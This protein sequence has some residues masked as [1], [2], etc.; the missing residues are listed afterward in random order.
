MKCATFIS[1]DC[2][3]LDF[4]GRHQLLVYIII[5]LNP[6]QK[7]GLRNSHLNFHRLTFYIL[8][9]YRDKI[10]AWLEKTMIHISKDINHLQ[11]QLTY[12]ETRVLVTNCS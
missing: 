12:L 1:Y 8:Q 5:T 11:Q 9:K 6:A 7:L 4:L 10:L 3:I 2:K